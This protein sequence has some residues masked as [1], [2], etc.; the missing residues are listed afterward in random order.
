MKFENAIESISIK[1]DEVKER[2]CGL[3]DMSFDIMQ[4][5]KKGGGEKGM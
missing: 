4:S 5:E 3:K 1:F 2:I